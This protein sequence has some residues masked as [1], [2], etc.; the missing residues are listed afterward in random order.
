[1]VAFGRD[2]VL[3]ELELISKPDMLCLES[4]KSCVQIKELI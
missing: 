1:M 3:I 2:E 4:K